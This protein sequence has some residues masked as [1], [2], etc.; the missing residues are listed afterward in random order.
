MKKMLGVTVLLLILISSLGAGEAKF[1]VIS[2]PHFYD[3]SLGINSA[4]FQAYL[5]QDRKMLAESEAILNSALGIVEEEQ[6]QFLIVPGDLT[7][8]GERINH[9]RMAAYFSD[10]EQQ[11]IQVYVIP[12]N[13]DIN[14]P[15]AIDFSGA[16]PQ[17]TPQVSPAEFV[18][19]YGAYGYDEAIAR[20][21]NSLSY[22]VEPVDGIWLFGMDAC[23]YDQ[24]TATT[25]VTAGEFSPET[26]NWLETKL[27]EAAA[28]NKFV[29]GMVHHGVWEHYAGQKI[30]FSQYVVNNFQDVAAMFSAHGMHIVFTGHYHAQDIVAATL[31][32]GSTLYDVET[33]SLVTYPCPVRTVVLNTTGQVDI[34]TR[35]V[36]SIAYDTEGV[37]F[38]EYALNYLTEG[39]NQLVLFILTAPPEQGGYGVPADQATLAVPYIVSAFVAHYAGDE[40]MTPEMA[41]VVGALMASTDPND[42]LVGMILGSLLIDPSP[43][44]NNVSLQLPGYPAFVSD[45]FRAQPVIFELKA[46]Y[47]NPFNP[48]TKLTF[49]LPK[50]AHVSL[51]VF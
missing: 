1:C 27:D 25:T 47:P 51:Q 49:T 30:F 3:A 40:T 18:E 7:K 42:L 41:A 9:E 36:T 5:L 19:I 33:G 39:L 11:G 23:L 13:H 29:V 16:V 8:D 50:A 10:L 38:Q 2:D 31:T 46:N 12:G 32:D 4:A 28:Q 48:A 44:D 15:H 22:I 6:P 14:N 45:N 21:P 20:D 17:P 34:S 37:P 43:G 26:L 35:L 24:N